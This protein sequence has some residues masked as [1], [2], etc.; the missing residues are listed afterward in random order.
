MIATIKYIKSKRE[1]ATMKQKLCLKLG[2]GVIV[3][4]LFPKLSTNFNFE[5]AIVLLLKKLGY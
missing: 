3:L 5:K 2:L 1:Q 4:T